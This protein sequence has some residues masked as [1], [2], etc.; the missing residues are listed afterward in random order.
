MEVDKET[1]AVKVTGYKQY[2]RGVFASNG[3]LLKIYTSDDLFKIYATREDSILRQSLENLTQDNTKASFE[4]WPISAVLPAAGLQFSGEPT[5]RA[6]RAQKML[7]IYEYNLEFT[8]EQLEERKKEVAIEKG[9]WDDR[10][11]KILFNQ[12]VEEVEQYSIVLEA[13]QLMAE[14][15]R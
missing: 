15:R 1:N 9:Y 11:T 7:P 5:E 6:L 13:L 3:D 2:A 10:M 4:A 14:E 8:K 12:S